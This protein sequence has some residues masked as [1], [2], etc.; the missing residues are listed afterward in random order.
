MPPFALVP[1]RVFTGERFL[2]RCAVVVADGVIADVM[3]TAALPPDMPR[4]EHPNQMLA[5]GWID[6]Q[7]NG[8]GGVLFNAEPT[9][10]ALRRLAAA[11]MPHGTTAMLP[12]FITDRPD[13]MSL[14]IA[15]VREAIARRVPGIAGLHLEGP[16]LSLARKG[17]HDP[18]LIR[19]LTDP[20]VDLLLASG[21]ETLL[22]TVAPENAAPRLIRRL[23]DGGVVVSLG[24]SDAAYDVAMAAADAGARGVTHLFNAMSQLEHRAPGMVG[25]ALDYGGLWAGLIADGHHVDPAA[26][27]IAL[28]AKRGPGRLFLVTDAMPPAASPGDVFELTGR[29]ATRRDGRLTLDDGTLAGSNLTM[30]R[31]VRYAV[32]QL[33]VPLSEALRMA[34]LYPACFL[35]CDARRGRI[36]AGYDADLILLSDNLRVTGVWANGLCRPS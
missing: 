9:V 27:R 22:V 6:A 24:H 25:A 10:D 17:A 2:D 34:S 18:A 1:G 12:T 4:S 35:R 23:V 33:Q 26:L 31:A 20:D 13:R 3:D 36:A 8:G 15:A 19:P 30:D 32:N 28:A 21:I 11:F 29:R 7:V 5:P 16:F 14:A